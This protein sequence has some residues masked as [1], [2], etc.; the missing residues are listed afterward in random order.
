MK[1]Q[2]AFVGIVH[3][4]HS[5]VIAFTERIATIGYTWAV[6]LAGKSGVSTEMAIFYIIS[7]K[8]AMASE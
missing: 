3:T 5:E 7:L 8:R 2:P 4:T 1:Y 6:H